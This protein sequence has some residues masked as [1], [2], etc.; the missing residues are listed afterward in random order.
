MEAKE[1]R[2]WAVA[3]HLSVLAG[4]LIPFAG[5]IAPIAIWMV[6]KDD[7]ALVAE[8]GRNVINMLIT[9]L[10]AAAISSILI[11]VVVGFV[12]LAV[13]GAYS[14]IMPIFAAVKTAN[15]E[16]FKYPFAYAFLK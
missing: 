11:I 3:L 10:I 1:E 14:I 5:L 8:E 12:M 15:G 9:L 2:N 6:K 4:Y 13:L 7:S 16:R